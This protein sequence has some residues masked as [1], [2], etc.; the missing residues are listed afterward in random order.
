MEYVRDYVMYMAVFGFFSFVWF[1]W[2]QENPR[3]SWRK[4][5]GVASGLGFVISSIGIYLSIQHWNDASALNQ[6][7]AFNLYLIFVW[8]E[9]IICMVGAILLTVFKKKHMIAPFVAFIVGSHFIGL[10]PVFADPTLY[11]LA[12]LIMVIS[13]VS[14]PVAKRLQVAPSAITGIGTGSVLFCFAILG[15]V[16]YLLV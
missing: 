6:A 3:P 14:L 5:I 10:A 11:L 8:A 7:T 4:Y 15:F 16:R 13:C 12:L 2:A 1:G 9:I